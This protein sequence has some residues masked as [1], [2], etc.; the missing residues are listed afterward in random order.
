MHVAAVNFGRLQ[1]GPTY[2]VPA[3]VQHQNN[4]EGVETCLLD[5]RC[6]GAIPDWLTAPVIKYRGLDRHTIKSMPER[7]QRPDI[8]VFHGVYFLAYARLARYFRHYG[9]PYV[10]TPRGS[11]TD[12]AQSLSRIK[13][14]VANRLFVNR[15][16]ENSA[17]IHCLTRGEAS[18]ITQWSVRQFVVGNGVS[19]ID[20]SR[21]AAPGTHPSVTFIY[22]GRLDVHNKGLDVLLEGV[23]RVAEDL[24]SSRVKI[25]IYGT[26]HKRGGRAFIC[27]QVKRL[28]IADI[29]C[30]H[31][32]V[33]GQ[34]KVR[35]LQLADMFVLLSRSE[36]HPLGVLE[37]LAYG[38]PVM[39]SPGT[40]MAEEVEEAGAGW[41]VTLTPAEIA[42]TFGKI[43]SVK[44]QWLAMGCEARQLVQERYT[45][46]RIAATTLK[47][48]R[49]I[50]SHDR[51]VD[52]L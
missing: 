49:R 19:E 35:V 6:P 8:A 29:V 11:L 25:D 1:S 24:R 50:L 46:P 28:G 12:F 2:S 39:L 44:D 26:D 4:V 33:F 5:I 10:I 30:L 36:G 34:D 20:D 40:N 22:I 45:W 52:L 16:V 27:G 17:A 31:E 3:L 32:A 41:N 14:H 48:Y 47:E 51:D 15:F 18:H 42:K 37:A 7:F 23:A 38:L 43:L 13:K 21:C 9:I